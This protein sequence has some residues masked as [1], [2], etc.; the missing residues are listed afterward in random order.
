MLKSVRA[1]IAAAFLFTSLVSAGALLLNPRFVDH[2]GRGV[3]V[4]WVLPVLAGAAFGAFFGSGLKR[5]AY[6][7]SSEAPERAL[8]L[9]WA[10]ATGFA[11]FFTSLAVLPPYLGTF[12]NSETI[13]YGGGLLLAGGLA[14]LAV[15]ATRY[16]ANRFRWWIWPLL[17]AL[18]VAVVLSGATEWGRGRG[19]SSR[20]LVLAAPGLSWNVAEDMIERGEMPHFAELRRRGAWGELQSVSQP[21]TPMVWTTI[22]TGKTSDEHGVVAFSSTAEDVKT[23]RVWDILQQRGW[24]VG[25]FGW[26]VTWP[27]PELGGF[28]VPAVSDVGTETSPRDLNFIR[29]LAM[30]EKTRQKRTWGRYWR[31]AFLATRYGVRLSTLLEAGQTIVTDPLR[32]GSLD[33]AALF[34]KRKLRAKLNADT[35]VELRRQHPVDFAAFYT[36]IV[37][38]AQSYFWQYHE[39]DAFQGI[40]PGDIARYGESVHDSY[41]IVDAFLGRILADTAE[42]DVVVVVSDHGAEARVETAREQL[43]LRVESMLREM[44]LQG[45]IEATNLGPRTYLRA[46]EG[47]EAARARVQRLFET[48][49]LGSGLRAFS[50][51]VDDWGNVVV[52]VNPDVLDH[53]SEVLLYQ[54]GRC[55]VSDVVRTVDFRES[56]QRKETGAIVMEGRGILP[57]AEFGRIQLVDVVP[58]LLVLAGF[59]LAADLPGDVATAALE[60]SR[61]NRFPGMVAT[62]E[63]ER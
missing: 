51:R 12:L 28:V 61:R 26:P 59:E 56:A 4:F 57:G 5:L 18:P 23:L 16:V 40:S 55:P 29:E 17:V 25:L 7:G 11:M 47:H 60:E 15:A 45:V 49:R 14:A 31:Y 35:F 50:A 42:N 33:A 13:R 39:P 53:L 27:P 54:G 52:T 21:L 46:K 44:R 24:S 43:T 48:A 34:T 41:R 2:F 63:T 3:A 8:E 19:D 6:I 20:I 62:Y 58:T 9:L 1:G 37:D 22:A 38:V 36:N 30:N 10:A 32:G